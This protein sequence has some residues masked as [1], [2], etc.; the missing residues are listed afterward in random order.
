MTRVTAPVVRP[1]R[2]DSL[3]AVAAPLSMST[4]S[5]S[6]SDSDRPNRM[7]T[8]WPNSDPWRLTRRR[9]RRTESIESRSMVDNI[10]S[11]G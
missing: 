6:M 3:P 7:A 5:A 2:S 11:L 1:V 10:S 9:E 8:V 4:S